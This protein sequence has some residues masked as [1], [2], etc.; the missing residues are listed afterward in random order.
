NMHTATCLLA[1]P[2]AD[3]LGL[4]GDDLA[5][6]EQRRELLFDGVVRRHLVHSQPFS[7]GLSGRATTGV[8][9]VAK[10]VDGGYVVSGRKIFASL[11]ESANIHNVVCLVPGD[12][13]VRLLG[14][15]AGAPGLTVTGDWD[16]LGMRGTIS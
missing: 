15:E 8:A 5:A 13:R 2:I 12:D 6:L 7:E 9:T 3:E 1:G 16:P 11:S 4:T 14:V 10:P